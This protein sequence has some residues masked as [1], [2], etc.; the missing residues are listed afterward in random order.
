[1]NDQGPRSSD[2]QC[3]LSGFVCAALIAA[4]IA[5]LWMLLDDAGAAQGRGPETGSAALLAPVV[6]FVY[7]IGAGFIASLSGML[8]ALASWIAVRYRRVMLGYLVVGIGSIL[9]CMFRSEL[10]LQIA[11][12]A[13][14]LLTLPAGFAVWREMARR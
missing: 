10:S 3:A 8:A 14:T 13:G 4:P 2:W 7:L 11:L 12:Q 6:A 1:M 9:A 5:L